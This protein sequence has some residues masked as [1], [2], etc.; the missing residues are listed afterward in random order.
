VDVLRIGLST[1]PMLYF[2]EASEE[3]VVGGVQ[4]TGSH[5]PK[6][7]NGFKIV[8]AGLP[9]FGVELQQLGADRVRPSSSAKAQGLVRGLS[10]AVSMA[11]ERGVVEHRESSSLMLTA[12][13]PIW[14]WLV[15]TGWLACGLDGC[16][17]GAAGAVVERLVPR[18][19]G[20]MSPCS[21]RLTAIFPITTQIRLLNQTS[22]ICVISSGETA[23]FW[24]GFR[25]RCGSDRAN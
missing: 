12:C 3:E 21:R 19:P 2:A 25:W 16:G 15:P 13:W 7:H 22:Q 18:L 9:F 17:N 1:T 6:D 4:V 14:T 5:N 24:C 11:F 23:R 10:W 20:S 8:C